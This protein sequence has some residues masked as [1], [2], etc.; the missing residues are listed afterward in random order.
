[1]DQLIPDPPKVELCEDQ[2]FLF[3]IACADFNGDG[4]DEILLSGREPADP[5]GWQLFATIYTYDP[6]S[7]NLTNQL[8]Q[9]IYTQPDPLYDIGNFNLATGHLLTT[10]KDQAIIGFYQ[11]SP[12]ARI[13]QTDDT[14]SVTIIP[15]ETDN[16]LSDI[17]VG[18]AVVQKRDTLDIDCMYARISTM[19]A[20]DVNTKKHHFRD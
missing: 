1:M 6:E 11:Y 15:F 2:L 8:K 17:L 14:V 18:S 20:Y 16:L 10:E 13:N 9:T 19:T 3:D 5:S 7:G 4:I 12:D